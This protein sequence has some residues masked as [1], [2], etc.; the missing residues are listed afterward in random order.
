MSRT[1]TLIDAGWD[2]VRATAERGQRA[3]ALARL[4]TLLAR[5][6]VPAALAAEGHR[7]AG[8]LAL[9]LGRYAAARRHLKVSAALDPGRG[10]THYLAGRAWEEDPDG[11]DRKAAICYRRAM[12]FGSQSLHRAAFGRA[13]ARCGKVRFGARAML[14]AAEQA[15]GDLAVVRIAVQGLLEAGRVAAARR[16]LIT[17]R[18]LRPGASELVALW[19]RVKFEAARQTQKAGATARTREIARYAQ[20]AHFATDGDRV[21]LPFVRVVRGAEAPKG[22]PD[23]V[24]GTVRRDVASFPRPHLARLRTRKADR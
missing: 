14:A 7:F 17:T 9:D 4:T 3:D 5:P 11:C 10:G 16:V 22:G 1:L 2:S 12:K 15:P 13:A 6:D 8:E 23:G 24:A 21:T 19:E 20:D 18:F